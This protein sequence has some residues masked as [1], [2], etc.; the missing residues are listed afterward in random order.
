[1]FIFFKHTLGILL[2]FNI[3][4][5]LLNNRAPGVFFKVIDF[6]AC[7]SSIYTAF[8][9]LSLLTK[10]T[11]YVNSIQKVI[12]CVNSSKSGSSNLLPFEAYS[13]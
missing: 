2:N 6:N 12:I 9:S 11:L 8:S 5:G 4:F 13:P 10:S 1:M 7:L 3:Y